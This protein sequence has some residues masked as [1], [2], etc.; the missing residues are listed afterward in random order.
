MK[1]VLLCLDS[2]TASILAG[3]AARGHNRSEFVR[4][5][6]LNYGLEAERVLFAF[7][8]AQ[9]KQGRKRSPYIQISS[10]PVA[11]QTCQELK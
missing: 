7:G 9:A 5:L 6:V 4:F 3:V 8:M 10:V 11:S 2:K 1:R